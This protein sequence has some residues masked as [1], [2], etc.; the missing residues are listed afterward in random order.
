MPDVRKAPQDSLCRRPAPQ[1]P[2]L[3]KARC[4]GK[5]VAQKAWG[6]GMDALKY[7]QDKLQDAAE[8]KPDNFYKNMRC[9]LDTRNMTVSVYVN[10]GAPALP[11]IVTFSYLDVVAFVADLEMKVKLFQALTKDALDYKAY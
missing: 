7:F 4:R 6:S 11:K 2:G 1:A 9:E 8:T 3:P 10:T 5:R